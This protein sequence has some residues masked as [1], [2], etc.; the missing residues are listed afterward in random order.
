MLDL[1]TGLTTGKVAF[2]QVNRFRYVDI[3][4]NPQ[5]EIME[6]VLIYD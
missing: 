6:M 5:M 4:R 3:I 2:R 1:R